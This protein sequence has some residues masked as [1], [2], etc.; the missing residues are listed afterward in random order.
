MDIT[1]WEQ[2]GSLLTYLLL[3]EQK[4]RAFEGNPNYI[5]LISKNYFDKYIN[6]EKVIVSED[7]IKDYEEKIK[8]IKSFKDSFI[9]TGV[10]PIYKYNRI[11]PD[12][13]NEYFNFIIE[14]YKKWFTE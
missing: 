6:K 10:Y 5:A 8:K 3:G 12:E 11:K 9:S 1:P 13:L 4:M 2:G 7:A 14:W